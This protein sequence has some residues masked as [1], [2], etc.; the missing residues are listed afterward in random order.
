M[1]D[2]AEKNPEAICYVVHVIG[3][4]SYNRVW[5]FTSGKGI[6]KKIHKHSRVR[7]I[8]ADEFY[9]LATGMDNAFYNLCKIIPVA[10]NDYIKLNNIN[11]SEVNNSDLK[12]YEKIDRKSSEKGIEVIDEIFEDTFFDY[13]GFRKKHIQLWIYLQGLED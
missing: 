6:N 3:K 4:S 13:L 9:K 2:I 11:I 1:V 5:E 8:T 10:I 12:L 7:E